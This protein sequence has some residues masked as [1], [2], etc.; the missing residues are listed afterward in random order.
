[1]KVDRQLGFLLLGIWL[2]VF[3]LNQ[4]VNLHFSQMPLVLGILA[5]ASGVLLIIRR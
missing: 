4:V 5:L 2:V 3:G 1:M